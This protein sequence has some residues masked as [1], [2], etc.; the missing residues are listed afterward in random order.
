MNKALILLAVFLGASGAQALS[1]NPSS[2]HAVVGGKIYRGGTVGGGYGP[3]VTDFSYPCDAGFTMVVNAY[4]NAPSQQVKCSNGRYLTYMG[5]HWKSG[6]SSADETVT[7]EVRRNGKVLVHCR[8][9]VDASAQVAYIVAAKAG[10]M[11]VEEAA[12]RFVKGPAG[13]PHKPM[14]PHILKRGR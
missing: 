4:S 13:V 8:H 12:D 1:I 2:V 3:P 9:G 14:V 10:L 6:K 5:N 7:A 11:S